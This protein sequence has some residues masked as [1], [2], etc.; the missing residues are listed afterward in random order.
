MAKNSDVSGWRNDP[1][2]DGW[3]WTDPHWD[4]RVSSES[5][6]AL[7]VEALRRGIDLRDASA[8]SGEGKG[9]TSRALF[10]ID[11]LNALFKLSVAERA[12]A[13]GLNLET[14]SGTGAEI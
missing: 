9:L 8:E 5:T 10:L 6:L 3:K 12:E 14:P 11:V 13:L 4:D 2:P 1:A 7:V